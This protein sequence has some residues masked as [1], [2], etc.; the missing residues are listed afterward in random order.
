[1][2]LEIGELIN[3]NLRSVETEQELVTKINVLIQELNTI[4]GNIN[5]SGLVEANSKF[6]TEIAKISEIVKKN[7]NL[8]NTFMKKQINSY[9]VTRDEVNKKIENLI[10]I[11]GLCID[12]DGNITSK[13]STARNKVIRTFTTTSEYDVSRLSS[14]ITNYEGRG[15][16]VIGADGKEYYKII[17]DVGY[18]AAGPGVHLANISGLD[19]SKYQVGGLIS[20]ELVDNHYNASLKG[21]RQHIED[22]LN[23]EKYSSIELNDAQMDSL[24]A[25]I[26]NTGSGKA[27]HFLNRYMEAQENNTTL[28]EWCTKYWVNA[29]GVKLGGLVTRRK[30]EA[31]LFEEGYEAWEIWNKEHP[32]GTPIY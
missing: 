1:M 12:K 29:N 9:N 6:S 25:L 22:L 28:Y 2:K 4:S 14:F 17:N 21:Y 10:K 11:V 19:L 20:K 15:T 16:V 18:L 8:I 30:A 27:E 26:Y 23:T 5:S 24:T 31:V 3:L 13:Y 32:L 7:L